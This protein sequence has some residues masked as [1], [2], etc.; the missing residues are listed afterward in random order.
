VERTLVRHPEIDID[1]AG[2]AARFE[3]GID[4]PVREA[5]RD[6]EVR[7]QGLEVDRL[8]FLE[9]GY[10]LAGDPE[11]VVLGVDDADE[12][13]GR[14]GHRDL[15]NALRERVAVLHR[16]VDD[17]RFH[18]LCGIGVLDRLACRLDVVLGLSR[19]GKAVDDALHLIL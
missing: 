18:A 9:R 13:C 14:F 7:L 5:V 11:R 10:L 19:T 16:N 4:R 17:D 1:R 8:A 15:D 2:D 3:L 6:H 12:A